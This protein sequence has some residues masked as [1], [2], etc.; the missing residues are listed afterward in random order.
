MKPKQMKVMLAAAASSLLLLFIYA[1]AFNS[2]SKPVVPNEH[3]SCTPEQ[4]VCVMKTMFNLEEGPRTLKSFTTLELPAE[5][6]ASIK[7]GLGWIAGAQLADGGWGAGFHAQQDIR[8]PH[9]V[10]ADPATTSLVCLSLLRT[11][12]TLDS[13]AY[14]KQLTKATEFLLKKVETW[15]P[16]F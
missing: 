12:N 8:D 14:Q 4:H 11:G 1:F 15:S 5:A 10:A 13:G 16:Q 7:A 6:T 9:A 2:P 3:I